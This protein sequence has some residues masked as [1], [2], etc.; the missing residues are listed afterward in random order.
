MATLIKIGKTY[1]NLDN[2]TEIEDGASGVLIVTFLGSATDPNCEVFSGDDAAT[3]RA[4][5]DNGGA[6]DIAAELA[7]YQQRIEDIKN[8]PY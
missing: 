4:W 3:L 6:R 2:V 8:S 5:L 1:I 7:G